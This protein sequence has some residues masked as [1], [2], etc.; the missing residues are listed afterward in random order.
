M[1]ELFAAEAKSK[2]LNAIRELNSIIRLQSSWEDQRMRKL[3]RGIGLAISTIDY[4]ILDRIYKEFPEL[5]DL[6]RE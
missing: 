2:C 5:D 6:K 1:D 3:K 4:E